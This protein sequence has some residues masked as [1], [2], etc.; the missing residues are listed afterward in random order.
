MTSSG[1]INTRLAYRCTA[2]VWLYVP[3]MSNSSSLKVF[4]HDAQF[5]RSRNLPCIRQDHRSCQELSQKT[6]CELL[7]ALALITLPLGE[8]PSVHH[9]ISVI[10]ACQDFVVGFSDPSKWFPL[11]CG[12]NQSLTT[13]PSRNEQGSE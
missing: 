6:I 8:L 1:Q 7:L 12:S 3:G 9:G 4:P 13:V 2:A 10:G 5:K 11:R